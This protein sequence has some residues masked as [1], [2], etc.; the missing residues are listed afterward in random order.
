MDAGRCNLGL[1]ARS[2]VGERTTGEP[3]IGIRR[4]LERNRGF[5]SLCEK[6]VRC[7]VDGDEGRSLMKWRGACI[8]SF[9]VMSVN[10][11]ESFNQNMDHAVLANE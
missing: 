3:A 7:G 10:L 5:T 4:E 11:M 1:D 8:E 2:E 9:D 6:E